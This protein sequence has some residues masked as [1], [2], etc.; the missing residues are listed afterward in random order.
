MKLVIII[1]IAFVLLI[2]L[3][4][5][6]S[7]QPKWVEN[8][9]AWFEKGEVSKQDVINAIEYLINQNILQESYLENKLTSH[10]CFDDARCI[11]GTVTKVID[12]DTIKVDGQSIRFALASAPELN[13]FGGVDARKFIETLCPV[14]STAIVDEDDGQ[15]EGS[16]GR[17]IGVIY[18]NGVNL[19]EELVDSSLGYLTTGFCDG[20]EFANDSWAQ[21]HGC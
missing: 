17:V 12:G 6:A 15:T 16:Y 7:S 3:S 21:K 9:L 5:F 2:P 19:N 8:I 10:D 1:A 14:G 11:T 13:E 20:S 18:C 4:V